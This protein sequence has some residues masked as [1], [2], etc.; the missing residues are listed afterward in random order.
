M[1]LYTYYSVKIGYNLLYPDI[2]MQ[3]YKKEMLSLEK[4]GH[5]TIMKLNAG[6]QSESGISAAKLCGI[7][8]FFW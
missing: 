4:W 1:N 3:V 8:S 6:S 2:I 5:I 7:T